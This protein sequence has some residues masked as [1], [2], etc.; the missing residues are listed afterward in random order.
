MELARVGPAHIAGTKVWD[1]NEDVLGTISEAWSERR[2][3]YHASEASTSTRTPRPTTPSRP[4]LTLAKSS[5]TSP[6]F[7]PSPHRPLSHL[8]YPAPPAAEGITNSSAGRS[9]T[10]ACCESWDGSLSRVRIVSSV[11]E[12]VVVNVESVLGR[13]SER[14]RREERVPACKEV[15]GSE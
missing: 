14:V 9:F 1:G 7:L 3:H 13:V 5:I 2:V 8:Q 12:T 10:L 11:L 4:T 6:T 15:S